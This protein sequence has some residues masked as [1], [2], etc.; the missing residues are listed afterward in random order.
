MKKNVFNSMMEFTAT[1][2][3]GFYKATNSVIPCYLEEV[4]TIGWVASYEDKKW[5]Q[6]SLSY[7]DAINM[8]G[9]NSVRVKKNALNNGND[10]IEVCDGFYSEELNFNDPKTAIAWLETKVPFSMKLEGVA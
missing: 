5:K 4:A 10:M 9:N 3:D 1:K 7:E 2:F 6:T 8:F